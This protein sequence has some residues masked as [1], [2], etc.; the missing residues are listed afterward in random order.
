MEEENLKHKLKLADQLQAEGK[1]LNA[2]QLLKSLMLTSD[3]E[4]IYFQLAELYED[5]GF[6]QSG[7]NTLLELNEIYPE[8][9]D[10]K[11]F[12]GQY[13][14]RNA[15]W[16]DAIE[17]LSDITSQRPLSLF[18][19]AY[20]Y[21]MLSDF[22]LSSDYFQKYVLSDNNQEL[23]QEANLYLAKIEYELQHY[24]VALKY[25]EEAQ[26]VYSNFWELNLILA[27]VYYSLGMYTHALTPIQKA[28]KYSSKEKS[29]LEFAGRIY[30]A[31]DEYEKAVNYFSDFIE[32]ST[33][34]SAEIYTL[35]ARSF[36]KL[37][38]VNE[39]SLFFQLALQIDPDYLPAASGINDINKFNY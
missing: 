7:K 15:Q 37:R 36:L 21:M 29:I 30:F 18:L 5:M 6:I 1:N 10:I 34:V 13:L 39:A 9:I 35:L 28:L 25:A 38:K 31:L 26:F 8:N 20:A 19:I 16:F 4:R 27:K 22:E 24:D 12:L 32:Q 3:D 14:L 17:T 33:E 23:I 2:L 11:L